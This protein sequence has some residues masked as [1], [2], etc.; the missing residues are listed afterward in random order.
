MKTTTKM[1]MAL[2]V[3]LA[4]VASACGAA[5]DKI[6]EKAAEQAA[7][8][9]IEA[10][11]D[12]NV[13]VDLS[14]DGDDASMKIETEDGSMSFGAGTEMPDG[15][16]IPVPDGGTVQTAITA[17]DAVMASLYYDEGR[18]EEIVGFYESWTSK[19]GSDWTKQSMDAST[20]D[21]TIRTTMWFQESED[22]MVTVGDCTAMG[23]DTMEI[24]SVCVTVTE[25]G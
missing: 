17:D 1:M 2:L 24:N 19:D 14:G 16:T 7:E 8:K 23:S 10:S 22:A 20:D 9:L 3:V 25:G 12:G 13:S 21:G 5:A 11:G 4:L 6:S 15:L 18:Y